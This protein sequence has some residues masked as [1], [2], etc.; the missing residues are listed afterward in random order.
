MKIL[1]KV[2]FDQVLEHFHSQHPVDAAYEVNT[3]KDAE[4]GLMMADKLLGEW[5]CVLLERKDILNTVLP[6]HLGCKGKQTLVPK[7][8]FNVEQTVKKLTAKQDS[9]CQDNL[10]CWNKI[11]RMKNSG[12]TPLF[13]STQAIPHEDYSE[14][15]IPGNL[16][17]LDGLHRMVSWE[18]HGMLKDGVQVEAYVA[19]RLELE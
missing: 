14:I 1:K 9:Y 8:G 13:L 18:F 4:Q 6:W 10:V 2:T 11:A 16:F 15:D 17:H 7:S 5:N 12:F 19:G 3:N